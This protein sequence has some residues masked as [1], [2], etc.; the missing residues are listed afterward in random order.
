MRNDLKDETLFHEIYV[1]YI[2]EQEHKR[3]MKT[4]RRGDCFEM[5]NGNSI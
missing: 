2:S 5:K 1:C 4:Y 3:N